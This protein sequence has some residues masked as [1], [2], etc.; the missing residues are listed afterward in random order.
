MLACANKEIREQLLSFPVPAKHL[1]EH[2]AQRNTLLQM[3]NL[4]HPYANVRPPFNLHDKIPFS[5]VSSI[6]NSVN[7]IESPLFQHYWDVN[8]TLIILKQVI[9]FTATYLLSSLS[10]R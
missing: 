2:C 3:I 5:Q 1:N 9:I 8:E 7:K 10:D 4:K 6:L